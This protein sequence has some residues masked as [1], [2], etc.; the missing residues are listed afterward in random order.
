MSAKLNTNIIKNPTIC[1]Y[2]KGRSGSN[3][4]AYSFKNEAYYDFLGEV[5]TI[6][7][8]WHGSS[9]IMHLLKIHRYYPQDLPLSCLQKALE[10][11]IE[12]APF[13]FDANKKYQFTNKMKAIFD[14]KELLVLILRSASTPN[15]GVIFKFMSWYPEM[16]KFDIL[17]IHKSIDVLILNYRKNILKQFISNLKGYQTQ[18]YINFTGDSKPKLIKW[19]KEEFLKYHQ[20]TI[21]YLS[22]SIKNFKQFNKSKMVVSYEDFTT[23]GN[24]PE[25]L[26]N[27]FQK[28]NINC[29][30]PEVEKGRLPTRQ[31]KPNTKLKDNFINS[32]EFLK[33]YKSIQDK[34][35]VPEDML[36]YLKNWS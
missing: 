12:C 16:F 2:G 32:N 28:Y 20:Y 31:S 22:E 35:F 9:F 36:T 8:N 34:I 7:N 3:I 33:D 17:D 24:M 4:L 19:N 18:E 30:V 13:A 26:E 15:R 1:I 14:F 29:I 25:Y 27:K 6:D 5:L 21:L 23:S 10:S 11:Y